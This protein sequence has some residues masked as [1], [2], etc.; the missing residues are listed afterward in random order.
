[1]ARRTH[2]EGRSAPAGKNAWE[3][4][5]DAL[6]RRSLTAREV[7][8]KLE[9]AGYPDPEID[10]VL[11]RL[12]RLSFVD[13]AQVAYNH[14]QRRAEE[15]RRGPVRVRAE[16]LSR[17]V[18]PALADE[19]IADAF[20]ADDVRDRIRRAA[21]KLAGSSGI[22]TDRAGRAKLARRLARAGFPVEAVSA[23][24]DERGDEEPP[25]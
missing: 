8:T 19:V 23:W 12:H 18:D 13:D 15:G 21:A 7:A 24:L 14:V 2:S 4:A 25:P 17:G 11:E 10:D 3:R 5:L 20:P 1:M 16:L 9:R 6:S 22:P